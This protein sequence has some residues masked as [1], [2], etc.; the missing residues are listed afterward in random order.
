MHFCDVAALPKEKACFRERYRATC[1]LLFF[2]SVRV[3]V[4]CCLFVA[5]AKPLPTDPAHISSHIAFATL[6]HKLLLLSAATW[7]D[8]S[9]AIEKRK[10]QDTCPQT[11]AC[12]TADTLTIKAVLA[13][14]VTLLSSCYRVVYC[15]VQ[16]VVVAGCCVSSS[17]AT[18]AAAI[19]A[20]QQGM[21]ICCASVCAAVVTI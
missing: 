12:A 17:A 15:R 11:S 19:A 20:V 18:V 6:L 3:C 8:C 13:A 2:C 14:L 9:E 5:T 4:C 1:P 10:N 21:C 16:I 7:Y